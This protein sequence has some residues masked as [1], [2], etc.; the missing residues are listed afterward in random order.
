MGGVRLWLRARVRARAN[1][2]D[3]EL[4]AASIAADRAGNRALGDEFRQA[5][6]TRCIDWPNEERREE[7]SG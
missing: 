7:D 3:D 5:W 1:Y 4:I 2:S 6:L